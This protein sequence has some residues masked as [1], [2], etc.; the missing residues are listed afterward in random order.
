MQRTCD[1]APTCVRT[2]SCSMKLKIKR[3]SR[4]I[5]FYYTV[6]SC[7]C[8]HA[9]HTPRPPSTPWNFC[10][11]PTWLGTPENDISVKNAIAQYFYG[12]DKQK[13]SETVKENSIK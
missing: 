11:F 12:K 1:T 3:I 9:C 4:Y 6:S 5:F 10:N 13:N 2:K 7:V 8:P